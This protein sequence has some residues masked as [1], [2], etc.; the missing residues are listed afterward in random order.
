MDQCLAYTVE[1]TITFLADNKKKKKGKA[2]PFLDL[3][4]IPTLY[5]DGKFRVEADILPK[6]KVLLHTPPG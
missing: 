6:P 3:N 2:T 5:E 4:T 1:S